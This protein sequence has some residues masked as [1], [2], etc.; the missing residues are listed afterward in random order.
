LNNIA[1]NNN[2]SNNAPNNNNNSKNKP[3]MPVIVNQNIPPRGNNNIIQNIAGQS[4]G[5]INLSSP[6]SNNN[7]NSKCPENVDNVMEKYINNEVIRC[8]IENFCKF[9]FQNGYCIVKNP[10]VQNSVQIAGGTSNQN[11]VFQNILQNNIAFDGNT[12][13]NFNHNANAASEASQVSGNNDNSDSERKRTK[14]I[15]NCPHT[16]RKHYAKNMCN[17]CYHKQGRVKKAWLC[18]HTTRPHY[19]RGKCQ[20]CYLN[21]YHKE[22]VSKR[23]GKAE[24]MTV[25]AKEE[26]KMDTLSNQLIE[27]SIS[28]YSEK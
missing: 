21:F 19:A 10:K 20:N 8:T 28:E 15:L 18:S 9:L 13:V 5:G 11:N 17:N 24:E 16:D 4:Q 3:S 27:P 12:S 2:N 26:D 14:E 23:K 6:N 1:I 25:T 22:Q 7:L